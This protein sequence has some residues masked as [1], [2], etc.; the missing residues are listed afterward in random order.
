MQQQK[1]TDQMAGLEPGKTGRTRREKTDFAR[2]CSFSS[3][4]DWSRRFQSCILRR[5]YLMSL[6]SAL[7]SFKTVVWTGKSGRA[8]K[9]TPKSCD[10]VENCR[11]GWTQVPLSLIM[12]VGPCDICTKHSQH[13]SVSNNTIS[14]LYSNVNVFTR[15]SQ[16][17]IHSSS[18]PV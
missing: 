18:R 5:S 1:L 14:L 17:H 13:H 7:V 2:S 9:H 3:L 12:Y 16:R 6:L 4:T 15:T 11:P 10:S 8:T